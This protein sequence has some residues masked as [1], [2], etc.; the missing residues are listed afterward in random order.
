[1]LVIAALVAV[2][3]VPS[4]H[5]RPADLEPDLLGVVSTATLWRRWREHLL[6]VQQRRPRTVSAYRWVYWAWVDHLGNKAWNRAGP[7]D[8]AR[9]LDRPTR[10]GRAQGTTLAPNTRLHYAATVKAL[11]AFAYESGE[12]RRDPMASVRLPR[13]GVPVTRAFG[14]SDLRTILLAADHDD[15]LYLACWLAYG[16]G[17][18]CAEIAA[19]AIE[20]VRMG[21]EHPSL[22]IHGKG[23]KDRILPLYPE[24]RAA[25]NRMLGQRGYPRV[26]PLITSRRTPGAPMTPGSVSRMLSDHIRKTC[27]LDGSGHGLRHSF[28][29]ELLDAAGEEYLKTVSLMLGHADTSVTERVYGLRY[30][31]K[32]QQVLD[33]L[34]NPRRP[35]G[36]MRG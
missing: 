25:I 1:L 29:E 17:L 16:Q 8:L 32:P 34:P 4:R 20:D 5:D 10:S 15:R 30:R 18:R 22:L 3:F 27:S 24:V 21:G 35:A 23:G 13:G 6:I 19:A 28:T 2:C 9:F 7:K 11:Y 26:G 31:G 12:L 14:L 36:R 33:K